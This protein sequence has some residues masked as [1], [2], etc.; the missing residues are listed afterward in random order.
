MDDDDDVNWDEFSKTEILSKDII[1]KLKE[2][3]KWIYFCQFSK[4]TESFM[5]EMIDYVERIIITTYKKLTELFKEKYKDDFD[6]D[7]V[8]FHQNNLSE[9]F[10]VKYSDKIK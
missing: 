6:W 9:E 3:L 5:E 7:I 1:Q 8:S 4:F 2:K 10:N